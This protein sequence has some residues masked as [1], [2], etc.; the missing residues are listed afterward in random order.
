MA[1]T[2]LKVDTIFS[3]SDLSAN[4]ITVNYEH[5]KQ[6]HNFSELRWSSEEALRLAVWIVSHAVENFYTAQVPIEDASTDVIEKHLNKLWGLK[7]GKSSSNEAYSSRWILAALSD[8]NG[9]LQARDMIRFL[10]YSANAGLNTQK[11]TGDNR[12][13]LPTDI[14]TAVSTCSKDKIEELKNEYT[15]LKPIL[16]R[17]EKIPSEKKVLPLNLENESL[18]AAEERIMMQEGFLIKDDGKLYLPEIIRHA[19]GFRYEK[20]ARPR[21]LSLMLKH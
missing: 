12:I 4:A 9:R 13:L 1:N 6:T 2:Y 20:G 15:A 19:L 8:F 11:A 5:F 7:L 3:R 14:R 16:E 10:Q 21:V 17:L 18:T